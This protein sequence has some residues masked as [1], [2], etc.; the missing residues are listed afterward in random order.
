M[1]PG[2]VR[3][4]ADVGELAGL[5]LLT[6]V[7]P[8]GLVDRVVAACGRAE[9]RRRLL[10]G[11]LVV[12]F[13]LALAQFSPAPYLEVMRHLVE[14]LRGPDL[15]LVHHALRE[16]MVRTAATRGLDLD[17]ISFTETLRSARRSVTLTPGSFSLTCWSEPSSCSSTTCSNA[18]C[19]TDACAASPASSSARCPTTGSNGPNS[20]PGLNPPTPAS[21]QSASN[22]P[23]RND[24]K[25][26]HWG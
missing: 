14:G 20:T 3:V 26:R 1:L 24:V 9:H 23:N 12:Y 13:A 15:L 2:V 6:W 17:R 25:Q 19:H 4:S 11:R 18:S 5:G 8:P 22:H 21:E 16:L 7:Y 10:P